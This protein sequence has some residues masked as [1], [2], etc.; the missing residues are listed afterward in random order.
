L[1]RAKLQM[2]MGMNTNKR[3][4]EKTKSDDEKKAE[5]DNT[6]IREFRQSAKI[7]WEGKQPDQSKV[8]KK[9]RDYRIE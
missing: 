4:M 9:I 2:F 7:E 8:R 6:G 1:E 5:N 3:A